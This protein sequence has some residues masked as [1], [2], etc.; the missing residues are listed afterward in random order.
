MSLFLGTFQYSVIF[1]ATTQ[2]LKSSIKYF[3]SK[4]DQIRR[5]LQIVTHLP[6]KSLM[7]FP[8]ETSSFMMVSGG[9]E[10]IQWH[11]IY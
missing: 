10:R 1:T 9:T 8:L 11:K 3:F 7:D 5:K 4:C 6:K 2:K